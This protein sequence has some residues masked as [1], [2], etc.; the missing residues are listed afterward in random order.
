M[1]TFITGAESAETMGSLLA[2]WY[3]TDFDTTIAIMG[4]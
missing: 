1:L 3:N 4:D 2:A